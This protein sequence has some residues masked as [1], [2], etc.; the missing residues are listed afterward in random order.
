[1]RILH[2]SDWHLGIS[3]HNISMNKEH[4]HFKNI[5]SRIIS[6]KNI[7]AVAICG[8]VFDSSVSNSEAISLYN[9]IVNEICLDLKIPMLVIAGNHDG[10]ARL[11][12]MRKL[13]EN[14]NMYVSG[15][16]EKEIKPISLGTADFYL[17]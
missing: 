4:K 17:I 3:I 7:D 11:S 2:T 13:L 5:L 8:D 1:M 16:L 10:A 6:E 12:S 14:S 15:K 9:D